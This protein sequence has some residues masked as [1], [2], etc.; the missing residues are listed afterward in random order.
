LKTIFLE[1]KSTIKCKTGNFLT[2]IKTFSKLDME[3]G[4]WI[5]ILAYIEAKRFGAG[6]RLNFSAK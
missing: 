3:Y 6:T 2:R 1:K 4:T 5:M